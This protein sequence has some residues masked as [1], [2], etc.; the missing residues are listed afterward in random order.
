MADGC[1]WPLA[2]SGNVRS[3]AAE[4]DDWASTQRLAP[5]DFQ[6]VHFQVGGWAVRRSS[7]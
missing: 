5:S 6:S 3:R 4:F 2:D 1:S 7:P